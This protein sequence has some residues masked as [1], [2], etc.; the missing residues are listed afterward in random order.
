MRG[1]GRGLMMGAFVGMAVAGG[2]LWRL[3]G[4]RFM[5]VRVRRGAPRLGLR[6]GAVEVGIPRFRR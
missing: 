6:N 5:A 3:R 1:F 4:G 2:F